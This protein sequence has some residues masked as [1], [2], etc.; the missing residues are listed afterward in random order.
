MGLYAAR[1]LGRNRY[2]VLGTLRK[3]STQRDAIR[4]RLKVFGAIERVGE[5]KK[6][7]RRPVGPL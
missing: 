4:K 6:T 5:R 3:V 1:D 7:E 2:P